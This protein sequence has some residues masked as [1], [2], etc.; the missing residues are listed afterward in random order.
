MGGKGGSPVTLQQPQVIPQ[1][2]RTCSRVQHLQL[3]L[4]QAHPTTVSVHLAI[5]SA[6]LQPQQMQLLGGRGDPAAPPHTPEARVP[7]SSRLELVQPQLCSN[8]GDQGQQARATVSY[9][10]KG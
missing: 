2:S 7:G 9:P 3:R 6:V 1:A 8:P 4:L 5:P 10:K